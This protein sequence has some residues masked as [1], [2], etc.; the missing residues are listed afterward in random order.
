M[1][2][3]KRLLAEVTELPIPS[4]MNSKMLCQVG[5]LSEALIAAWL[6]ADKR[7]LS[8][9]DSQ[10][11]KEV[12]PLSEDQGAVFMITAQNLDFPHGPGVL[13]LVYSELPGVGNGLFYFKS[14]E[15]KSRSMLDINLGLWRD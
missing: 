4:R 2:I 6:S 15:V 8:S 7:T 9:V 13:E 14:T 12:V 3:C 10:V 1:L 11:I 5:L